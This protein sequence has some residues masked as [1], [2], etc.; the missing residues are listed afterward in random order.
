MARRRHPGPSVDQLIAQSDGQLY[1]AGFPGAYGA[2]D[3]FYDAL[4]L[5]GH[6]EPGPPAPQDGVAFSTFASQLPVTP[7]ADPGPS[8]AARLLLPGHELPPQAEI[9]DAE[10]AALDRVPMT[11]GAGR[12]YQFATQV[13]GWCG[14]DA[15]VDQQSELLGQL[16]LERLCA[17]ERWRTIGVK[18]DGQ[19]RP[20]FRSANEFCRTIFRMRGRSAHKSSVSRTRNAAR[21]YLRLKYRGAPLPASLDTLEPFGRHPLAVDTYVALVEQLGG[22]LPSPGQIKVAAN[23]MKATNRA[24]PKAAVPEPA[25]RS[26]RSGA[27]TAPPTAW[28]QATW[29]RL[30]DY[31]DAQEDP[32]LA[33]ML[34]ELHQSY[35]PEAERVVEQPSRLPVYPAGLPSPITFSETAGEAGDITL[36]MEVAALP[37]PAPY[38]VR[39]RIPRRAPWSVTSHPDGRLTIRVP[40]SSNPPQAREQRALA[41]TW[42][43][44]LCL[45]LQAPI[46][47]GM[48]P[49][50]AIMT[51]LPA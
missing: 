42:A 28:Q 38:Y 34:E 50:S 23:A 44:R 36:T 25:R 17:E 32:V 2:R 7:L 5:L 46:P 37:D 14:N 40:V 21:L 11:D 20:L 3:L 41:H 26:R 12:T 47:S 6:Q 1:Y 49:V 9:L 33:M 22:H 48:E 8:L 31:A 35:L 45:D 27:K 24:V 19:L 43:T 13:V 30:H 10:L 39:S 18:I 15:R 29:Q 4:Q 16:A 51:S